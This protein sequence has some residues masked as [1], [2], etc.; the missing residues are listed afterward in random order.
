VIELGG[1]SPQIV[2]DDA[3]LATAVE[4]IIGSGVRTAGQV[5]SA[6]SRILV[7]HGVYDELL[8]RLAAS[9]RTI[10]IDVAA[11]NPD[12]GPLVSARQKEAVNA[13]IVAAEKGGARS[14][15]GGSAPLEDVP[16]NGF[17]VRPTVF[18]D[19]EPEGA[20]AQEEIFGP[21][22]AVIPF[23]DAIEALDIAENTPF[24][25]VAGV[26]T[27]DIGRAL[28]LSKRLSAGQVFVNNYGVGGGVELPFGGYR[29]SGIGREKGLEAL[30]T[31][32]QLK[33][34]CVRA[35]V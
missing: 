30:R 5:C 3:D 23:D 10:R 2:F 35:R 32:T 18:A 9:V 34:V 22:L 1:K 11:E 6:G 29:A 7:Q 4:A 25:L 17:F 21:V 16:P 8:E 20:L 13:A 26:W 24:G 28:A 14:V 33:N 19:V 12:M 27:A 31:Y 15:A